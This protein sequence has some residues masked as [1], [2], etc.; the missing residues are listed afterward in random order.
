MIISNVVIAVQ[1]CHGVGGDPRCSPQISLAH[2]SVNEQFPEFIVR[3]DHIGALRSENS[4]FLLYQILTLGTI[5]FRTPMR[6]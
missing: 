2:F 5:G 4:T 1:F 6:K 3:D